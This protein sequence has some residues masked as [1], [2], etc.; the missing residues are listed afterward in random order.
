MVSSMHKKTFVL[1]AILC[2]IGATVG[3][4]FYMGVFPTTSM[5][6][7]NVGAALILVFEVIVFL[8]ASE[9]S[10][11]KYDSLRFPN[12]TEIQIPMFNA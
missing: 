8:V 9:T 12:T 2:I 10:L 4:C 11:E 6:D 5:D 1:L 3:I 7:V